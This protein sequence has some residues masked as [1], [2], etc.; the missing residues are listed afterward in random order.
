[1][2]ELSP[3]EKRIYDYIS[4]TILK[5]GYSPSVRDIQNALSI[6]STST[7]HSY[8]ARLETAGY[9]YKEN[10]KSRTIRIDRD[11]GELKYKIPL[12]GDIRKN[13]PINADENFDG[14]VDFIPQKGSDI[15]KLFAYKIHNRDFEIKGILKN[16]ILILEKNDS[17]MKGDTVL[18]LQEDAIVVATFDPSLLRDSSV[19]GRVISLLR[20]YS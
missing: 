20:H 14:Y 17:P 1:M 6:K 15:N 16:D 19:I 11:P 10:G 18:L 13:A 2:S 8:L 4:Q 3:A 12:L 9:I 5:K 7:V